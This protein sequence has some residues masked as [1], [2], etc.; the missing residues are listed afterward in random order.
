MILNAAVDDLV[1]AILVV[2]VFVDLAGV[3]RRI[4]DDH[5]DRRFALPIDPL[6]VGLVED[7]ER[8][9]APFSAVS[10]VSTRQM[11]SNAS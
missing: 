11:P 8:R 5:L 1:F 3:V 7:V 2:V 4:G 6:R 10:K 9:V